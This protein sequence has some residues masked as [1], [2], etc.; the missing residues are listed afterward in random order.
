MS[1]GPQERW[2]WVDLPA[3]DVEAPDLAVDAWLSPLGFIP[4]VVALFLFNPEVVLGHPGAADPGWTERV[5]PPDCCAYH[6]HP[7]GYNR[8]RQVWT[9]GR[10]RDLAT[11]LRDRG[12]APFLSLMELFGEGGPTSTTAWTTAHPEVWVTHR[13]IGPYR[14]VCHYK[15]LADGTWYEDYF[16]DRLRQALLDFGFAGF[17]QA[18]GVSHPRLA[19]WV[20]DHSDDLIAQFAEHS[21][22]ALPGA[23]GQPCGGNLEVVRARADWIW[24][25]R[26]RAWIDFY[27]DRTTRFCRKV[28]DAVHA[29]GGRVL[30][31]GAD[32]RDPFEILY[33]YGTDVRRLAEFVDGFIAETVAPGC[34]VGAGSGHDTAAEYNYHA[35]LLL[36]KAAARERPV[37]CLNGV[38]D[39]AEQWDV[40]RHAPALM[41]REAT[42]QASRFR[43]TATGQLERC[44]HGPMVCLGDGIRPHEWAWLREWW[45]R[46]HAPELRPRTVTLVWSDAALDTELD[47]YLQT[48]RYTTHKLLQE[49]L[50]HGAPV[51]AVVR[52]EHVAALP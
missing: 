19:L 50:R 2:V 44:C 36:L 22:E 37:L 3:F 35:M 39:V 31:N 29:A 49:L 23:L 45:D 13:N 10:L 33:R 4:D 14:S 5:L 51:H 43:W 27:A 41:E 40:L 21:G 8:P 25:H 26:R 47:G 12:V 11:A 24:T 17:H 15:R 34:S 46:A 48:Q 42:T 32:T 30:L 7:Y 20:G 38:R 28:A 52:A 16:A 1:H 18:D 6:A 9:A